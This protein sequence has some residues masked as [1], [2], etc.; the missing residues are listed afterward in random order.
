MGACPSRET[1]L[2]FIAPM[3]PLPRPGQAAASS[4]AGE[5]ELLALDLVGGDGLLAVVG[6]Q[7]VDEGLSRLG[8]DVPVALRDR[9][10]SR[11]SG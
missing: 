10:G 3:Y 4:G 8:L 9:R 7:P 1:G 6:H 2:V 5:E 11:H